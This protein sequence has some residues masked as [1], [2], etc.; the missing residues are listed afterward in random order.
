MSASESRLG[1]HELHT[2]Q[3]EFRQYSCYKTV[4]SPL[5]E[6]EAS[7]VDTWCNSVPTCDR[8]VSE[9]V[10]PECIVSN[11]VRLY[12]LSGFLFALLG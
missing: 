5:P 11:T 7:T 1:Y 12:L 9:S 8:G 6:T 4:P 10:V 2:H 3:L